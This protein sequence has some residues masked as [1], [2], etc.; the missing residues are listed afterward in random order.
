LSVL[1]YKPHIPIMR[2][3]TVS[4]TIRGFAISHYSARIGNKRIMQIRL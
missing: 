1:I 4:W 3:T 2:P